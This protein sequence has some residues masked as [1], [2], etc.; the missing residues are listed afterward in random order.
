MMEV[1]VKKKRGYV[2]PFLK[3]TVRVGSLDG[4]SKRLNCMP[5]S[6]T[7]MLTSYS[8]GP[9]ILPYLVVGSLQRESS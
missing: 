4:V 9:Q 7:G 2:A 1:G 5:P 3:A 8:S 6:K